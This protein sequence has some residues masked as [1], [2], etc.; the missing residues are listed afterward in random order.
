MLFS[1]SDATAVWAIVTNVL[2]VP[3]YT[4]PRSALQ[5]TASLSRWPWAVAQTYKMLELVETLRSSTPVLP[6]HFHFIEHFEKVYT[7]TARRQMAAFGWRCGS[8]ASSVG[9]VQMPW[10]PGSI[11][12]LAQLGQ[13]MPVGEL[14]SNP[15]LPFYK[16]DI[17]VYTSGPR[18]VKQLVQ[19]HTVN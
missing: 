16:W 4:A 10:G 17:C 11:R 6:S 5:L 12:S 3:D 15:T 9:S 19:G 18:E 2:S 13:H 7:L 8:G 14:R 1:L